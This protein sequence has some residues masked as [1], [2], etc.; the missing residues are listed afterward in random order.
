MRSSKVAL[1]A[2]ATLAFMTFAPILVIASHAGRNASGNNSIY[3][4]ARF[5]F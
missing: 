5:V 1:P 3:L 4:L 2:T